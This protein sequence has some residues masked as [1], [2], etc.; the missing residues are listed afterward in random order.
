LPSVL[1]QHYVMMTY[2]FAFATME[3]PEWEMPEFISPLLC[4]PNS[5]DLD[6]VDYNVWNILQENVY[7]THIKLHS[8]TSNIASEPSGITPLLLQPCVSGVVVSQFA[9]G[10]AA[11]ILSTAF[12]ALWHCAF[13]I[14]MAF[15]AYASLTS[16]IEPMQADVS[17]WLSYA[18]LYS[19]KMVIQIQQKIINI[20]I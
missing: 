10:W 18:K 4:H 12:N 7:N 2:V 13:A 8:L 6:P 15:E 20:Y 16:R 1:A 17:V 11:V 19:P 5:P 14:T 3:F 9:S